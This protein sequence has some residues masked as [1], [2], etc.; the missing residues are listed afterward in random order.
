VTGIRDGREQGVI[1]PL[2]IR[3]ERALSYS[4]LV[5]NDVPTD[6][7]EPDAS[8]PGNSGLTPEIA[9]ELVRLA[10]SHAQGRL[11]DQDFRAARSR[12]LDSLSGADE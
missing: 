7:T 12:L 3:D 6:A 2:L 4:P 8:T 10:E 9:N 5:P 1:Q 11:S